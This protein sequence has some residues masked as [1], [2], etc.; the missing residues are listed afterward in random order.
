M[1][2]TQLLSGLFLSLGLLMPVVGGNADKTA[3][4][5]CCAKNL[6]CCGKD[7]DGACCATTTK[8]GCCAKA[9]NCC[10][11]NEACCAAVQPCCGQGAACC[12]DARA[13]CGPHTKK[14]TS[15]T[16]KKGCCVDGCCA[17]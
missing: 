10:A 9:M 8:L 1:L 14:A 6:A 7:Y 17:R 4:Q 5:D 13:C 3:Q 11:R 12:D 16:A 2:F 15:K